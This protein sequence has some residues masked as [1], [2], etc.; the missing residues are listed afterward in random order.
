MDRVG[1]KDEY[2]TNGQNKLEVQKSGGEGRIEADPL[3]DQVVANQIEIRA[4]P[5]PYGA[6]HLTEN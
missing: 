1:Y 6:I 4:P 5:Y 2:M 3:E